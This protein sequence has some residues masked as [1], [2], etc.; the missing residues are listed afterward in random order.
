MQETKLSL[1]NNVDRYHHKHKKIDYVKV[2][3]LAAH[4]VYAFVYEIS[5]IGEGA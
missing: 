2:E 3:K 1:E 4:I 5:R